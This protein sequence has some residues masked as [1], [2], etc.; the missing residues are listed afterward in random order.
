MRT[1]LQGL[2]LAGDLVAKF[3]KPNVIQVAIQ[4]GTFQQ[5]G[6]ATARG[7]AAFVQDKDLVSIA[8]RADAL[9]NDERRPAAHQA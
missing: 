5:L 6:M 3:V 7:D 8:H 2:P 9:G 1:S 4:F